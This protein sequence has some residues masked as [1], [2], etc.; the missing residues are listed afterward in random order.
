MAILSSPLQLITSTPLTTRCFTAATIV[1]SSLYYLKRWSDGPFPV[2]YSTPYLTLVPGTSLFYPWTF[3]TAGLVETTVLE[4]LLSLIFVPVSL[5]YLERLWGSLETFIFIAI[6]TTLPNVVSFVINWAEFLITRNAD[7]FLYNIEYHGQMALQTGILV[8]F[9]QLIPEHQVQV[10]GVIRVRV[11]RLPMA[12]VTL[13][14]VLVLLGFQSPWINIQW[15]WLVAWTYLRFYKKNKGDA[16]VGDSYGDRSETFA[17]AQWFP[18]FIHPPINM[19]GN[20]VYPLA[21][22]FRV[23]PR[24]GS[25]IESGG[26]AQLPGGP[27]AE[28]E[29]RRALALKA[30]DQ[31]MASSAAPAKE[32]AVQP[33]QPGSPSPSSSPSSPASDFGRL[34]PN[35]RHRSVTEVDIGVS[36]S[37]GKGKGKANAV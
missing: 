21:T 7:L 25:D 6:V 30:L 11:K 19:L 3:F 24:A 2:P 37:E 23:I 1:F 14:T 34:H 35:D 32:P 29:R 18:P 10:F 16:I 15:G 26:Y 31:R 28:A 20:F 9:T 4:L 27:R 17:F 33:P 36:D 13:S 5:R 12:Y 22:R 8:A